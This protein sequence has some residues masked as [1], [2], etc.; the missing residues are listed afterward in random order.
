MEGLTS[1]K[2]EVRGKTIH[3]LRSG[4][5]QQVLIEL[6]AQP[7][8]NKHKLHSLF[9]PRQFYFFLALWDLQ[10]QTGRLR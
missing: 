10:L 1:E 4:H 8:E 2:V 9:S 3:V 6:T 7:L 5:G